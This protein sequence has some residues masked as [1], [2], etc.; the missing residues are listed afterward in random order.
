MKIFVALILFGIIC[1]LSEACTS[2]QRTRARGRNPKIIATSPPVTEGVEEA[3]ETP[4][5][6]A[7]EAITAT[8]NPNIIRSLPFITEAP[9][10]EATEAIMSTEPPVATE[11]V[12]ELTTEAAE[13]VTEVATEKPVVA[14]TKQ[15]VAQA[16]TK[17]PT[18]AA[19]PT[20]PKAV[21]AS[22]VLVDPVTRPTSV[23]R[24]FKQSAFVSSGTDDRTCPDVGGECRKECNGTT[25]YNRGQFQCSSGSCCVKR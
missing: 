4:T 9:T 12:V 23:H 15:E 6:K 16:T 2:S 11:G 19:A 5:E 13:K 8:I 7:T 21:E 25:E 20:E 17:A 1:T 18:E 10:E 3:T 22:T 14:T 24:F